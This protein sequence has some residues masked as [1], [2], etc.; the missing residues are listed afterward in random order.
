MIKKRRGQTSIEYLIILGFVTFAIIGIILVAY[1][2]SG[3]ISDRLTLNQVDNAA[4]K[5]I[6]SSE[7][8]FYAGEPSTAY[9]SVTLPAHVQNVTIYN[10]SLYIQTATS[11]GLVS[12]EYASNVMLQG[13]IS[14]SEG[15]R[16]IKLVAN[17]DRVV[18]S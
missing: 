12:R 7:S 6:S 9:I 18:I 16:R 8:L 4:N 13:S 2:Y 3:I 5:I 10:Y 15:L 17:P 11:A 1:V 14:S